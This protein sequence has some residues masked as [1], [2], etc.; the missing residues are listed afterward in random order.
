MPIMPERLGRRKLFKR[1]LGIGGGGIAL[2][3]D[4]GFAARAFQPTY[5]ITPYALLKTEK[6]ARELAS[7]VTFP[8]YEEFTL[9][10]ENRLIGVRP[11]A[12][13]FAQSMLLM[14]YREGGEQAIDLVFKSV[15]SRRLEIGFE[16]L[17]NPFFAGSVLSIPE[18]LQERPFT[19]KI[20]PSVVYGYYNNQQDLPSTGDHEIYHVYQ[21]I[22][23][24]I[25]V[26]IARDLLAMY[27]LGGICLYSPGRKL[28][29]E[30]FDKK[31]SRR[32]LLHFAI[33]FGLYWALS[34]FLAPKELQAYLQTGSALRESGATIVSD[35]AFNRIRKNLFTFT[36]LS[37]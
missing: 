27:I 20:R 28:V 34:N 30:I 9:E 21:Y 1:A 2:A 6:L 32:T 26:T 31:V 16:N 24:G 17:V 10:T 33:N 8:G 12:E 4:V 18:V 15:R 23:D 7:S 29:D 25:A 3:A 22:R 11:N 13:V 19:V 14:S 36:E 35:P 37:P 5:E